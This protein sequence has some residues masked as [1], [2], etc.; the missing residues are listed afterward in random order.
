MKDSFAT[1]LGAVF[2][3]AAGAVGLGNI[4]KFPYMVGENGGGA[5]ILIYLICLALFGV[6]LMI[7]EFTIGKQSGFGCAKAFQTLAG[8]KRWNWIG[9][10]MVAAD[11]LVGG[12]YFVVT[13]WCVYYGYEAL[14]GQL[15]GASPEQL[16]T[17]FAQFVTTPWMTTLC[18]VLALIITI[19]VLYKG[20]QKGIE[21]ISTYLMPV[22]LV[23]LAVLMVFVLMLPGSGE[24]IRFFITPN[25]SAIT[26]RMILAAMGQCFFSLCI[27]A[28]VILTYGAYMPQE[29]NVSRSSAQIVGIDLAVALLAS[30]VVIPAVFAFKMS[31]A[32]GPKLVFEVLPLVFSRMPAP[33]LVGALFFVLLLLA[34]LTSTICIMEVPIA[35]LMEAHGISRK[36]ALGI[37]SGLLLIMVVMVAWSM[38][39]RYS[40]LMPGGNDLFAWLDMLTS[41]VMLPLSAF[42]MSIFMGWVVP[43][44][45]KFHPVFQFLIRYFIP[46]VVM[47][48][49]INGLL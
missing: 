22:L 8:N 40:W 16:Q 28:G 19:L 49:F 21:K 46:L 11:T 26:P 17:L 36:K 47:A 3:A 25:F 10:M 37:V 18:G 27:G 45:A 32:E 15:T 6:P 31:P 29:Q 44:H 48:I 9:Y 35:F 12:F 7:T 43:R 41:R 34:A 1:K 42:M 30:M 20:V 14:T 4:W 23:I 5:F 13:G 24:G 38:A 39:G 33:Y 2:A